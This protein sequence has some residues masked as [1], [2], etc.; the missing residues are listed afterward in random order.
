MAFTTAKKSMLI[1]CTLISISLNFAIS[2]T[3]NTYSTAFE[4]DFRVKHLKSGDNVTFPVKMDNVTVHYN[5]TFPNSGK[6][7]DSSY[8]R[9]STFTF[10]LYNNKVIKCWDQVVEKMSL[11]ERIYVVCPSSLAYGSTGAG[12]IIP[13]NTDIAFDINLLCIN[14]NCQPKWP[15][16]KTNL[17]ISSSFLK[18]ISFI[19]IILLISIF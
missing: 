6:S 15:Q 10:E 3:S 2:Q 4:N 19:M 14:S 13:A 11:G 7:F 8:S 16:I 18:K 12:D 5:G 1:L 9:N 17:T